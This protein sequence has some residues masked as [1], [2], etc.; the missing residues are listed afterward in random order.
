V[1]RPAFW[2][3]LGLISLGATAAAV[4]YF[5]QAFSIVALDITMTRERAL[6]DARAIVARDQLGPP[7]FRQAASFALDN[8]TQTFVELE[9]GGKGE[10]TRM[11]RE[12]LYAAYT[13]RVRHFREG[14]TNETLVRFT[15]DGQPYGFVETLKEDAPGAALDAADA[16]RRAEEAARARWRIDLALFGLV[17]Q[18][19][20][21]RP[22][23]RVDHTL[24]YERSAPTLGEGRYRL[25]LVVSG[26]RLTEVT[27]FVQIPEA[28][29]RRYDSMRSANEAIGI[30]SLVG[31][32]LLYVVGG[33][34]IGL[35]FM[36]RNRYVLWRPAAI[37]GGIVGTLQALATL[38]EWPLMWMTYDTAVPRTTFI[39]GQIATLAA[40]VVG[41]S[42]FM[43]LSFM[44]AETLT[45]R[46]F[47]H[48]PQFWRVW[49][50]GPGSST[51]ILGRTAAGYLLVAMFF[52]YDVGLYLIA[53]RVFGW[54][55]PSEALLHPDVLAT[56]VPWLS[57]IANS[58]Q[59]G[60]W[61]ECLFRAVPLAGAALI[62]DRFGKRGL[63]LAVAFIVQ[64]IIF[65]A[66][67]APY[68]TQPSYARPVE[69]IL[70]SIGFGLLYVYY[71]LLPGI[72]LH[73]AF[74]VVWFALPIFLSDAPGIWVQKVMV[75][76]MTFVPLLVV[77]WRRWQVGAWTELSRSDLN[78]AWTPPPAPEPEAAAPA[79]A[80]QGLGPRTRGAWLALGAIGIAVC[81]W[82]AIAER[83]RS[84]MFTVSRTEAA[85]IA[86][87][88]VAA[89]GATLGPQWRVLPVPDDGRGGPHEF[90]S[91]T[92]GEDRRRQL[93]GKYLTEPRWNVRIATFEGDVAERAEEWR[94]FVTKAHQVLRVEH[95]LPE[96]RPGATLDE[97]A[98]R[99]R[100]V[101]VV[102]RD[103]GLDVASGQAREVSA[104]PE[105]LKAR[106]DWTFI[107]ADTSLPPLPQGE[108][109]LQ[110]ELAGDEVSGARRFVFVPEEW[111]R[112]QRAAQTRN[113]IVR[114]VG[115][116]VFGG[117]LVSAAILGIV[118]WSRRQYTP[119]LFFAAAGIMLVVTVAAA[120]NAWPSTQAQM[121]TQIPLPIQIL[122]AI[123]VGL[124]ALIM[125]SSL[126]GLALGAQPARLSPLGI[127]TERDA[128][129][130]GGAIGAFGAA[131]LAVAGALR[132]PPWAAGASLAPLGAFVPVLSVALEPLAGFLTRAAIILSLLVNV[133]HATLGWTHRRVV[134]GVVLTL[135]G[136]LAAGAPAGSEMSGWAGAGAVLA[137]GLLATYTTVL[138]ADLTMV[139]I[140]LGTMIA[141]GA[142]TR[143]A[144]R[145]FPGALPGSLVAAALT[146]LLAWWLFRALRRWRVA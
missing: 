35:F 16:R 79:I 143:G 133:T 78:L 118:A 29:T 41:F 31:M 108:L 83:D 42:A 63:F 130:L 73:F 136:F 115:G 4:H 56:Y 105:K 95:T 109:R 48:H 104:R 103:F 40:T 81:V 25:R 33:I 131:L 89:R 23:G 9:G 3:L 84:E 11:L 20:E 141:L 122:G 145:P 125:T 50:K 106:T 96:A 44:A 30:G 17:E 134:A 46:A 57:A 1:R 27:H 94:V 121:P 19:Q 123:G 59:A 65:G 137:V 64:A 15:P 26:D 36:L 8:E 91:V 51:A 140:A 135:V 37:W 6:N 116:I 126:A 38:N 120:I 49:S 66:G 92:A 139:P 127:L 142:L 34:G 144:Q 138:R 82:A 71:G 77:L 70:P 32:V 21:R 87:A 53:T 5:P 69:L 54:W 129:L 18:G 75:I 128:L 55:T 24:T 124:V 102:A 76:A 67:H 112:Q 110:V 72:V 111:D 52:A 7:G 45:R 99:V 80:H 47:G 22:G 101:A 12:Q 114:I 86:R 61:E 68:P 10:F 62:G 113:L 14:E 93:L 117:L 90:V 39:A 13:W 43:A 2:I 100:A 97:A 107:F 119:R 132:T 146:A 28:F 58:L 88:A 98:A 60:F 74:D 85:D